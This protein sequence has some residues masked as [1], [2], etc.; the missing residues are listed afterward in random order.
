MVEERSRIFPLLII[1]GPGFIDYKVF[2]CQRRKETKYLGLSPGCR[3]ATWQLYPTFPPTRLNRPNTR[4]SLL[5]FP[6]L[7]RKE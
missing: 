4:S 3:N 2:C 7:Q 1:R 6:P 5:P